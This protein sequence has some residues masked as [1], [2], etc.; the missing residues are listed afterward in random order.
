MTII[1]QASL[2]SL[3]LNLPLHRWEDN[4]P[5]AKR[6]K[7]NEQQRNDENVDAATPMMVIEECA[8][9][10]IMEVDSEQVLQDILQEFKGNPSVGEIFRQC[11]MRGIVLSC[12]DREA[13]KRFVA[14]YWE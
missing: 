6:R 7:L 13:L 5:T 10:D 12:Q 14:N 1:H 4:P 9:D 11:A 2:R 8:G 3:S